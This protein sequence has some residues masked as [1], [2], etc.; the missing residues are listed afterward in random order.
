[1]ARNF[2]LQTLTQV[3]PRIAAADAARRVTGA[4]RMD[5]NVVYMT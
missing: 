2:I 4:K 3:F 1:V 5:R